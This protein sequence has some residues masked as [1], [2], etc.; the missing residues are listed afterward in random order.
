MQLPFLASGTLVPRQARTPQHVIRLARRGRGGGAQGDEVAAASTAT[1]SGPLALLTEAAQEI[2]RT[3]PALPVAASFT[4]Q[5]FSACFMYLARADR[6]IGDRA[7]LAIQLT[8]GALS[9]PHLQSD[10]HLRTTFDH[11]MHLLNQAALGNAQRHELATGIMS[12]ST[13]HKFAPELAQLDT[14]LRHLC[15]ADALK[16]EVQTDLVS[17][18]CSAMVERG[19]VM[20]NQVSAALAHLAE[21]SFANEQ[22]PGS[23]RVS[24]MKHLLAAAHHEYITFDDATN[25][26]L[27]TLGLALIE[28]DEQPLH[29]RLSTTAHFL[30]HLN[31]SRSPVDP[32]QAKRIIATA[33]RFLERRHLAAD[34]RVHFGIELAGSDMRRLYDFSAD[35]K[36]HILRTCANIANSP[37]LSHEIRSTALFMVLKSVSN[38]A[39][40]M[41]NDDAL[42]LVAGARDAIHGL[43]N[44]HFK[45]KMTMSM[46]TGI[47]T[48]KLHASSEHA[49][50][51]M[52]QAR[53]LIGTNPH[54]T[55]NDNL[56]LACDVAS[57]LRSRRIPDSHFS[58]AVAYR[59]AFVRQALELF[60][61][62]G[63]LPVSHARLASVLIADAAEGRLPIAADSVPILH[64]I[65]TGY[66]QH[67]QLS[68]QFRG[69]I[70][71]SLESATAAGVLERLSPVDQASAS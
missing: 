60:P 65:I 66:A 3:N 57:M 7:A 12:M 14:I 27:R 38:G 32:D 36:C 34:A 5:M 11:G 68:P 56:E 58:D 26:R 39:L 29:L 6:A 40:S 8:N 71:E 64:A 67:A 35:E 19:A 49:F 55:E 23:R 69:S 44:G 61:M 59:S 21:S 37:E 51:F 25:T 9:A 33:M 16:P 63:P 28:Q 46:F 13:L 48:G 50:L 1:D 70:A 2:G 10:A 15:Y 47:H 17:D 54:L 4:P 45:T 22:I 20:P 43:P 31:K 62:R 24:M 18:L 53:G 30:T 42:T 41:S 52:D